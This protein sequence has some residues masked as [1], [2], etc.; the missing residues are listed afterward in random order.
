MQNTKC[1]LIFQPNFPFS[2]LYYKNNYSSSSLAE[3][4]KRWRVSR[5][6]ALHNLLSLFHFPFIQFYLVSVKINIKVEDNLQ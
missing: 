4:D 5:L 2:H 3:E 6:N 1:G